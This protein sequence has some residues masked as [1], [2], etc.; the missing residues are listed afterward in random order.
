MV[1]MEKAE[2]SGKMATQPKAATL[3]RNMISTPAKAMIV[4]PQVRGGIFSFKNQPENNAVRIGLMND[5]ATAS[6]SGMMYIAEKK[7][8]VPTNRQNPRAI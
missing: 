6:A 2:I 4:A 8:I 7:V 5:I 1:D 3:G